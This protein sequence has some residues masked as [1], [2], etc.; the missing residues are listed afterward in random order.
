[1]EN[2]P[3]T[4]YRG[5]ISDA[6]SA[7]HEHD[8]FDR[9]Q[10]VRINAD[11]ERGVRQRPGRHDGD[12][13]ARAGIPCLAD[14]GR[15]GLDGGTTIVDARSHRIRVRRREPFHA[16]ESAGAVDLGIASRRS[17]KGRGCAR[18]H[19]DVLWG[20]ERVQASRG[21]V[22]GI[23]NGGVPVRLAD[24]ISEEI[25]HDVVWANVRL[26]YREGVYWCNKVLTGWQWHRRV[27]AIG[28]KIAKGPPEGRALPDHN[29]ARCSSS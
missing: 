13:C 10:E 21:V 29:Q 22:R 5:T 4:C 27:P 25:A 26:K 19:F 12:F 28:V 6:N 1:L 11:K 16:A 3:L 14:R 23:L 20:R 15:D 7:A 9:I 18:M 2:P 8:P 24:W 17:E